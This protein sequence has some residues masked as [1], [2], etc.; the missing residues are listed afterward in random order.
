ML[1]I[2]NTVPEIRQNMNCKYILDPTKH[3]FHDTSLVFKDNMY[4]NNHCVVRGRGIPVN[5]NI[6]NPNTQLDFNQQPMN[7]VDGIYWTD[8]FSKVRVTMINGKTLLAVTTFARIHNSGFKQMTIYVGENLYAS[9]HDNSHIN[10][11]R[12]DQNNLFT[13]ICSKSGVSEYVCSCENKSENIDKDNGAFRYFHPS[14]PCYYAWG[15]VFL[16]KVADTCYALKCFPSTGIRMEKN[17]LFR[18]M[19]SLRLRIDRWKR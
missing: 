9:T 3:S 13:P 14:P 18:R 16:E 17:I 4:S 15:T 19:P 2:K 11:T 1:Y 6:L 10:M 5:L 7:H 8:D 12:M